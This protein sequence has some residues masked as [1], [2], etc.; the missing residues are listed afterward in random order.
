M[1]QRISPPE[2]VAEVDRL[3]AATEQQRDHIALTQAHPRRLV[4]NPCSDPAHC[5][6]G[7]YG[8]EEEAD[9]VRRTGLM[10]GEGNPPHDPGAQGNF[11]PPDRA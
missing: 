4:R 6:H 11:T 2:K 5:T 3:L 7:C 10:P 9:H 1:K 8:T